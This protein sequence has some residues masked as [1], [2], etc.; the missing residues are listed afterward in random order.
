MLA[1][2]P[3]RFP[4]ILKQNFSSYHLYVI[5]VKS[6]LLAKTHKQ[7]FS[8]LKDANIGV[9]LHY[10]PIHLHPYYRK[11]GFEEGMFPNAEKYFS[12]A[13]SIPL[14]PNLS[15]KD[16]SFIASSLEKILSK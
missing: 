2:L 8:E 1:K 14:Y 12:E 9:N 15:D 6:E 7:I 11:L 13:I 3:I 10:I 4:K 5:R 16:Q